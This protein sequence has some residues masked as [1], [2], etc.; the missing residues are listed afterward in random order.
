MHLDH[1]YNRVLGFEPKTLSSNRRTDVTAV[2]TNKDASRVEVASK[3]DVP[4]KLASRNVAL[5]AELRAKGYN[6]QPPVVVRP[7]KK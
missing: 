4:A 3:T 6:P 2:H 1:G 7:T 5:D